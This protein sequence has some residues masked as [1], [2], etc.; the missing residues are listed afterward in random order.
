MHDTHEWLIYRLAETKTWK[1]KVVHKFLFLV[2]ISLCVNIYFIYQKQDLES[3]KHLP[4]LSW[5][6]LHD[7]RFRGFLGCIQEFFPAWKLPNNVPPRPALFLRCD[8]KNGQIKVSKISG[9]HCFE[10]SLHVQIISKSTENCPVSLNFTLVL[11]ETA[12]IP[13]SVKRDRLYPAPVLL[14]IQLV[15]FKLKFYV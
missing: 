7:F 8:G 11:G 6:S 2:G 13:S 9:E 5:L 3:R 10:C 12:S 14:I 15:W 4:D 1:K